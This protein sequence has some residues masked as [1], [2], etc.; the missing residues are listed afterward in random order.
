MSDNKYLKR[1]K[2]STPSSE[3]KIALRA[4]VLDEIKSLGEALCL[5]LEEA[6]GW[7]VKF[8]CQEIPPLPSAVALGNTETS[9]HML[10][11]DP[12]ND[13]HDTRPHRFVNVLSCWFSS[14]G[15]FP[16]EIRYADVIRV[17]KGISEVKKELMEAGVKRLPFVLN[18][19]GECLTRVSTVISLSEST[20][21]PVVGP[22]GNIQPE[23]AEATT[24]E[25]TG[26]D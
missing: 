11:L 10:A 19:V 1:L 25:A 24:N 22:T 17:C 7:Q 12:R 26:R 8:V 20:E 13:E 2:A 4:K 14:D 6:K 16:C 9:G 18:E 3:K 23:D 5:L 21:T 15:C